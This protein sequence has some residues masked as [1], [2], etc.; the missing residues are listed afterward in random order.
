[1]WIIVSVRRNHDVETKSI[2]GGGR[3]D[4]NGRNGR[5]LYAWGLAK[6]GTKLSQSL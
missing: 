3:K 4:E 1:M 2:S 6:K 5:N